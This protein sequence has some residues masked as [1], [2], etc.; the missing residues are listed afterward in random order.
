LRSGFPHCSAVTTRWRRV[1]TWD[2]SILGRGFDMDDGVG[3][4]WV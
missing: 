4:L 3:D 1:L 2:L